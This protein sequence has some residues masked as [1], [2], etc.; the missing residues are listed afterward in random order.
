MTGKPRDLS[1]QSRIDAPQSSTKTAK[2]PPQKL[3]RSDHQAQTLD[4]YV[5]TDPPGN[6][7]EFNTASGG[8]STGSLFEKSPSL[9]H[10][11]SSSNKRGVPVDPP[12]GL[13]S[14][15]K[16]EESV[17]KL[18][19]VQ[20]IRRRIKQSKDSGM[21]SVEGSY[22]ATTSSRVFLDHKLT[23]DMLTSQ[24]SKTWSENMCL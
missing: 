6:T 23:F 21:W 9:T 22:F 4:S 15:S 19:S 24:H 1:Q 12:S 16:I 11:S 13:N 5:R 17:C 10:P 3:V 20:E 8:S 2:L 7:L 14:S 18:A